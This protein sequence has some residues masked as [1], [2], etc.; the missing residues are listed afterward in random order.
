VWHW[1]HLLYVRLKR[2]WRRGFIEGWVRGTGGV[3]VGTMTNK[4][5]YNAKNHPLALENG[6]LVALVS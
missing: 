6:T 5:H 1:D 4:D 3:K 2:G